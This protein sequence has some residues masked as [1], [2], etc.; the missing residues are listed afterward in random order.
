MTFQHALYGAIVA[1]VAGCGDAKTTL[2][3]TPDFFYDARPPDAVMYCDPLAV[4]GQQGCATGEMCG[5]IRVQDTPS[6]VGVIGCVPVG[7]KAIGATCARGDTGTVTGYDDCVLGAVC[8]GDGA[9]AVCR[10]L[11]DPAAATSTCASSETCTT[12]PGVGG[13][14]SPGMPMLGACAPM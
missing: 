8:V 6:I 9:A 1:V 12:Y 14:G 13:D 2:D 7:T 10:T 4:A 5:W 11:C 3:A